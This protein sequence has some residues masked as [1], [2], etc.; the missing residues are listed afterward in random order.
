VAWWNRTQRRAMV[1]SAQRMTASEQASYNRLGQA[2]HDRSFT[3]RDL[4][5][6]INYASKFYGKSLKNVEF[7]AAERKG[8]EWVASENKTVI[9]AVNRLHVQ[10][11]V[12]QY[13][14]LMFL[15]GEGLLFAT[16]N[17]DTKQERWE[18]VSKD[19]LR[20]LDGGRYQR[21]GAPGLLAEDLV[22]AMR[23]A[24]SSDPNAVPG[25]LLPE[26]TVVYRLWE[27]HPRYSQLSDSPMRSVLD[28]CEEL[29]LLTQS[30]RSRALNRASGNGILLWPEEATYKDDGVV[31]DEDAEQDP[32]LDDIIE[33]MSAPTIDP[34][35]ASAVVPLLVRMASQFIGEANGGPRHLLLGHDGQ[36]PYGEAEVRADTIKRLAIGLDMPPEILLGL[37]DSNH[38][39]AWQ[40]DEQ[41][42]E[43][44]I[45]PVTVTLC[46]NLT[47][48]YLW[49]TIAGSVTNPQDFMVAYDEA[50]VVKRPDRSTDAKDLHDRGAINDRALRE[51]AAFDDADMPTPEE[52]NSNPRV[53]LSLAR[54]AAGGGPAE[55]TGDPAE[56]PAAPGP[57][58]ASATGETAALE[59]AALAALVRCRELA[60]NRILSVHRKTGSD[61]ILWDADT[62]PSMLAAKVGPTIV[63]RLTRKPEIDLVQG[64]AKLLLEPLA[65]LGYTADEALCVQ[66][67]VEQYAA[68]TLYEERPGPI[69]LELL[70]AP[71]FG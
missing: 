61:S 48:H 69:P 33:A 7:Y 18:F 28:I 52:P 68:A 65:Q 31:G 45:L 41:V 1:S 43:A 27:P 35:A 30:I 58:D 20:V 60:G 3:Y 19:E 16:L 66:A 37:Q 22:D 71:C 25:T 39:T 26:Q 32:L 67:A 15:T 13:G 5:G 59:G 2:W 36:S 42:W 29:V 62:S 23:G 38:W 54:A 8:N 47:E 56:T 55:A 6:E 49:P 53:I 10:S 12:Y 34:G 11:W 9:D 17:E 40:I 63:T 21:I 70:E 4:L 51:A 14:V 44:H 46:T 24:N 50:G 64:G 57:P